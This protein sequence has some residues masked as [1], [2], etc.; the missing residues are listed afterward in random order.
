MQSP[1][2]S[3]AMYL[4]EKPEYKKETAMLIEEFLKQRIEGMRNE[5]GVKATQTFPYR[6]G[7]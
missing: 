7:A 4:D 1:F 5:Y 2:L 6:L 3:L